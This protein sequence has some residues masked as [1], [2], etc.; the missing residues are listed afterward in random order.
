KKL[1]ATMHRFK[2]DVEFTI[3]PSGLDLEPFYARS[4]TKESIQALKDELGIKPDEFVA[5]LVARVAKEKSIDDLI[6]AFVAFHGQYS[7]SRFLIIGD[8][9]DRPALQKLIDQYHA[10]SFIQM[11]GFI[12]S[13]EHTSELQ[14]RENL[15]CRLLLEKKKINTSCIL[16]LYS[17][18]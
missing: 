6:H 3:I 14:S 16:Y 5:I 11:L 2:H 12:R 7:N 4:Y 9:P 15:V 13:E 10:N 17:F 1:Y 8:G 18:C